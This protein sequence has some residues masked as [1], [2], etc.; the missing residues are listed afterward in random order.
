MGEMGSSDYD[1]AHAYDMIIT[2]LA[3]VRSGN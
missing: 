3:A 2:K 1:K